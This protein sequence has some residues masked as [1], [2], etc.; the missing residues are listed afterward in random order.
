MGALPLDNPLAGRQ[1]SPRLIATALRAAIIRGRLAPDAPLRQE[2]LARHFSVSR[3]PLREALRQLE[4]EGWVEFLP[5]RGA[6]VSRLDAAEAR[7]IFEMRAALE[8]AALKLAVPRHTRASWQEVARLLSDSQRE[9]RR[10][11]Y[12]R[13][14]RDFHLALYRPAQRPRLLALIASLH[15]RG[16][17]YLRLK[18]DIPAYKQQSDAEHAQI[19]AAAS[20]GRIGQALRILEGHLLKTGEMLAGRLGAPP[21]YAGQSGARQ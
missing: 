1:S 13:R 12:V 5:H 17:R 15:D 9:S 2:E 3:I 18:L 21:A 20:G 14:N 19:F 8:C 16:E 4:S 7:E 10:S 11:R 6:R